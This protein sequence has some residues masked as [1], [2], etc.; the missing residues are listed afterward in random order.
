[1]KHF[2]TNGIL[3]QTFFIVLLT[4]LQILILGND[5]EGQCWEQQFPYSE[6][7][8][9]NDIFF[10]NSQLGWRLGYKGLVEKTINGGDT[11]VKTNGIDRYSLD[12][13]IFWRPLWYEFSSLQFV[14]ADLGFIVGHGFDNSVIFRSTDGGLNWH[15]ISDHFY[16]PG[17]K[18]IFFIDEEIGWAVGGG[19][20]YN[21]GTIMHTEDGGKD[22]NCQLSTSKELNDVYFIDQS[23][24]W[25]VGNDGLILKTD[26]GGESWDVIDS[27]VFAD[28]YAV[29]FT[30]QNHGWIAS[31]GGVLITND[32]GN[33]WDIPS[34]LTGNYKDIQFINQNIG[35]AVGNRIVKTTDGGNSWTTMISNGSRR[36]NAIA[37]S[38]S[39]NGWIVGE[40]GIALHTEDQGGTWNDFGFEPL[41]DY[42]DGDNW[43]WNIQFLDENNGFS[44]LGTQL[45]KTMDGGN[46]WNLLTTSSSETLGSLFFASS[47]IGWVGGKYDNLLYKTSNCGDSWILQHS[48]T[49]GNILDIFFLDEDTGWVLETNNDDGTNLMRTINGG[50]VW[51]TI[52]LSS[53]NGIDAY[54]QLQ[55]FNSNVGFITFGKQLL[56]TEDGGFTFNTITGFEVSDFSFID[57]NNGWIK[58]GG[59]GDNFDVYRTLTGGEELELVSSL[60]VNDGIFRIGFADEQKGWLVGR[61]SQ[62]FFTNDGGYHWEK[63]TLQEGVSLTGL[64][65]LD[66]NNIWIS[67]LEGL[68]LKSNFSGLSCSVSLRH[69]ENGQ[70]NVDP[71][72]QLKWEPAGGCAL[73]YYISLGSTPG[74][75]DIVNMLDVK[76]STSWQPMTAL[77][78]N[79]TIYISIH[80][81]N[82]E[83]TNTSCQSFSFTTAA[84]S[85]RL[86]DSLALVAVYESTNG[87][88]WEMPWNLNMP[89]HSWT[90]V[91]IS[92][93]GCVNKLELD[94]DELSGSI[95][96]EIGDLTEIEVLVIRENL[97]GEIPASIG[98]LSELK[99]LDLS[100]NNLSGNIPETFKNLKKLEKVYLYN[101]NLS[102]E[103]PQEIETAWSKI[104]FIHLG[105]NSF[106]GKAFMPQSSSLSWIYLTNNSFDSLQNYSNSN[107]WYFNHNSKIGRLF[108][109][110]N[111]FTFDDILQNM[112]LLEVDS[113]MFQYN[114]QDS[115][116]SDTLIQIPPGQNLT[117]DLLIDDT[118]TTN[119]YY[120]F[121]N[122][123]SYDTIYGNNELSF[124]NLQESDAGI[125]N[126]QVQNPHAPD[127]TLFSRD[128]TLQICDGVI[129]DYQITICPEDSVE[130]NGTYYSLTNPEGTEIIVGSSVEGCDSIVNV[131]LAFYSVQK[132]T[133]FAEICPGEVYEL[134]GQS[135]SSPGT[136]QQF[137]TSPEG[138]ENIT[139]INIAQLVTPIIISPLQTT[140]TICEGETLPEVMLEL[141]SG[142]TIDWYNSNADSIP[143]IQSNNILTTL[144]PGTYFA[145]ARNLTTGCT[146]TERLAIEI[147]SVSDSIEI[148][149]YLCP[150]E[151]YLLGNTIIN[152]PGQY[153]QLLTSEQGCDSTIILTLESIDSESFDTNDDEYLFLQ[154][155]SQ[156][157]LDLIEN[158]QTPPGNWFTEL[159][160]PPSHGTANLSIEGQLEYTLANPAFLGVDSFSYRLCTD[161]C[162]DTCMTATIT[163]SV[164]RDCLQEIE[165]NLPTGFTPDGDGI[166]DYF[167]P[168]AEVTGI[169][170]LQNPENAQLT[171]I[172]RWGEIVYQTANYA[173][174]DGTFNNGKIVPQGTYYYVLRFDL[175]EEVVLRKHVHVLR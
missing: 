126:V 148:Q 124:I 146:S 151:E 163:I 87:E 53:E 16:L 19:S 140:Y 147:I 141:T 2:S 80:P 105:N 102:G 25:A 118:V 129:S 121:K 139:N 44:V 70:A 12:P 51:E 164:L 18:E 57:E 119:I 84:Q 159:V 167:D 132:D 114:F 94:F 24:G 120:W 37:F 111:Q 134:N 52:N 62:I 144:E 122:D 11:W 130:I 10:L 160:L 104:W 28:L 90:G 89:I 133:I 107:S 17:I 78:A 174:W 142:T 56:K 35:L 143:I 113:N 125:Y 117:L 91:S 36:L 153:T 165:E 43:A 138:C 33:T 156:I 27:G 46:T 13:E 150:D 29:V 131:L 158:D 103:I 88:N 173:P 162:A 85:C 168:I 106:S 55:F 63:H 86:Q 101:N 76:S 38:D 50:L 7:T 5:L 39:E 64:T 128:I 6:T 45:L 66:H 69:P 31:G 93:N 65:I 8:E 169:G 135:Y 22:W 96:T 47:E 34:S 170:C 77:P 92:Q 83:G 49:T 108:I 166:N 20:F 42:S 71:Q 82:Y 136:Y 60:T 21:V 157:N 110:G 100:N 1:M 99:I 154:G 54:S 172:N 95:P 30:D 41:Y 74:G 67:G 9:Y 123:Q 149:A 73:G 26:N 32:G 137:F 97:V 81:Y 127:L 115:I 72:S 15:I 3:R 79:Q 155:Q 61:E 98:Q 40:S 48:N 58:Q 59:L 175:G 112:E 68:I 14:N 4:F 161:V 109:K 23:T 171:I 152:T 116:F 75:E 145:E